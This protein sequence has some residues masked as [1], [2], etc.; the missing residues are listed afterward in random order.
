M[1]FVV[2]KI[3]PLWSPAGYDVPDEATGLTP[4]QKNIVQNTWKIVRADTKKNGIAFFMRFFEAHP[5]YQKLF[6]G[7]ADVPKSELPKNGKL[8]GH[9]LSVMYAINSI[10][11]NLND[12]ESLVQVL[13]KIGI[14]HGPRKIT[15]SHFQNLAIVLINFLKEAL[16]PS[17]MDA[18]AE[19]AWRKSLEVANSLIIKALEMKDS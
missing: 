18:T 19:E 6:K 10:V 3:W 1:G 2:S 15:G 14:S 13:E 17:L 9:A 12:P 8:L 4:R 7:F 16:G 5:E 11:D